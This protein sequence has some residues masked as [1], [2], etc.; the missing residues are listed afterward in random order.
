[1]VAAQRVVAAQRIGKAILARRAEKGLSQRD[2]AQQANIRQ[3]TL[4][5]IERGET[6]PQPRT[7][8][9][10]ESVLEWSLGTLEAVGETGEPPASETVP[11]GG[12]ADGLLG[13]TR[14]VIDTSRQAASTLPDPHVDPAV[15]LAMA[16]NVVR[17]LGHAGALLTRGVRSSEMGEAMKLVAE[18]NKTKDAVMADIA[19]SPAAMSGHRLYVWRRDSGVDLQTVS[20]MTGLS[21]ERLAEL[22]NAQPPTDN[23]TR[24]LTKIVGE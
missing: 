16:M 5:S 9:R 8:V 10:I 3:G 22:E 15:Y 4:G 12:A 14:V 6:Y 23:E 18:I 11:E 13:M 17:T 21:A 20:G 1:M 7:R 19:A 2:L 24:I